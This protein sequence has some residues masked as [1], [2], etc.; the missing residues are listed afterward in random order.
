MTTF[1]PL[2]YELEEYAG[3][4]ARRE[5]WDSFACE[6]RDSPME[7]KLIRLGGFVLKGGNLNDVL[8]LYAEGRDF[9]YR[10]QVQSCVLIYIINLMSGGILNIYM[11][12]PILDR[13]KRLDKEELVLLLTE[14]L[15]RRI[16]QTYAYINGD[17]EK[18]WEVSKEDLLADDILLK[19]E[20]EHWRSHPEEDFGWYLKKEGRWD[21]PNFCL[22]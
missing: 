18:H 20:E 4:V 17:I 9:T 13:L 19:I 1:S 22:W 6:W 15:K 3:Y 5:Y 21:D 8:D 7:A 2:N 10:H 14:E 16:R 12:S 11:K